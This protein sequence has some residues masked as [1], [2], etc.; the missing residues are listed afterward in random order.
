MKERIRSLCREKHAVVLAHY[1]ARDEVQAVADFVGDSLALAQYAAKTDA[2]V[3]VVCGVD[4]MAETCKILCPDR[5][6]LVPVKGAA[7][8]LADSCRAEDLG[9]FMESHPG[10]KVVSYVNTT[11]EVKALSYVCVTSGNAMKVINSFPAD[12][13]LLFC[14]DKN[15]G[16]Y[17][18]RLTGRDM[19]LWDGGCH[20]HA[21]FSADGVRKLKSRYADAIVLAHPECREEVL[22]E[23][24][25]AGSTAKMLEYVNSSQATTFIVATEPGIFF[26]LRTEHP[27]KRFIS[28]QEISADCQGMK[29]STL[30]GIYECLTT[31][32]PEIIVDN[33][34]AHKAAIPIKRMLELS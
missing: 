14:P 13:K 17:I 24:D 25:F 34:L 10:Y 7:C 5:K 20:V 18:N 27:D 22:Q 30:E 9:K 31:E 23:A 15:L 6:V 8:S 12:E 26:Q 4:F 1:Y 19:L 11:A 3:L 33:E 32:K 16:G 29:L 21:R 28:A 2:E